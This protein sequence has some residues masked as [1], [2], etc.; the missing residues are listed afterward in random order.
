MEI[1]LHPLLAKCWW[2]ALY[3]LLILVPGIQSSRDQSLPDRHK[4][5]DQKADRIGQLDYQTDYSHK[6]YTR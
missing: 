5:I 4:N 6:D 2:Y 1:L 3:N